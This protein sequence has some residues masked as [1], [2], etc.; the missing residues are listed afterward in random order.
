VCWRGE[1]FRI[2]PRPT[3]GPRTI[4]DT[5]RGWRLLLAS[6]HLGPKPL[7]AKPKS[8]NHIQGGA[9]AEKL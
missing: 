3:S 5:A 9:E 7:H 2:T 1:S 4:Q 6:S 8:T